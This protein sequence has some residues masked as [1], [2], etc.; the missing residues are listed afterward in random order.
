MSKQQGVLTLLLKLGRDAPAE[1]TLD[2]THLGDPAVCSS[3]EED[4]LLMIQTADVF[5][6]N[7]HRPF[8]YHAKFFNRHAKALLGELH[9][10]HL[11]QD[12]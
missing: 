10:C 1:K 2:I 5:V 4:I 9:V 6:M 7:N 3:S 12:K 8:A 11:K